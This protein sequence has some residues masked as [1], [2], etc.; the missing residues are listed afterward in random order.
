MN[1]I[2]LGSTKPT[3]I[4]L[5]DI[6]SRIWLK[7]VSKMMI[8]PKKTVQDCRY[9][10]SS[11]GTQ[12]IRPAASISLMRFLKEVRHPIRSWGPQKGRYS[13][14]LL[15]L[16]FMTKKLLIKLLIEGGNP[17]RFKVR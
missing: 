2:H 3:R 6:N 1:L 4:R 8:L 12:F 17:S 7:E 10:L 14:N 11:R 9:K 15:S 13:L 5:K 16:S